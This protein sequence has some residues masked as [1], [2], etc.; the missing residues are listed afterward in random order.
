MQNIYD[1]LITEPLRSFYFKG[2]W[3]KN[4]PVQEICSRLTGVEGAWWTA[5]KERMDECG[6]LVER[7]FVSWDTT[8]SVILYFAF[9][10][11]IIVYLVCYCVIVRPIVN[12]INKKS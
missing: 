4:I 8:I 7:E 9:L 10:S 1:F 6:A 12:A 11:F 3:W 2:P 5:S